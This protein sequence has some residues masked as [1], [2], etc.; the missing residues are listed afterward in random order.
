MSDTEHNKGTL[1]PVEMIGG[2]ESAAKRI[3]QKEGWDADEDTYMEALENYGYRKYVH[4][5]GVIY[6]VDNKSVDVD[7]D[8]F[9][10]T[11][12]DDGTISYETK[13]YNGGCSFDEA[14][15]EAM[16]NSNI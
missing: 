1:T 9:N 2:I 15:E 16:K 7:M 14:L 11:K 4:L 13:F 5:N 10:A 8:I 6:K 3:L 12:N